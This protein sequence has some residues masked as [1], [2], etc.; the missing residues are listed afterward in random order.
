MYHAIDYHSSASSPSWRFLLRPRRFIGSA[1]SSPSSLPLCPFR[2]K[3]RDFCTWEYMALP[4][5]VANRCSISRQPSR[6]P[7]PRVIF[8][9]N[10]EFFADTIFKAFGKVLSSSFVR[11]QTSSLIRWIDNAAFI[12]AFFVRT[13]TFSKPFASSLD[14]PIY[15]WENRSGRGG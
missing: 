15:R 9:R 6:G 7:S 11:R 12:S 4:G 2:R 1:R 5:D 8:S 13:V 14:F 10:T 3:W